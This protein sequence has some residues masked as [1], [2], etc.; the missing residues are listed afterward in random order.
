MK[1]GTKVILGVIGV[2]IIGGAIGANGD[3]KPKE[4]TTPEKS[5]S[6]VVTTTPQSKTD[7][8]LTVKSTT[9]PTTTSESKTEAVAPII[10]EPVTEAP[11]EPSETLS[12]KNALRSAK[13]YISMMGFSYTGLIQQLEFEGYPH[14]DAVYGA[15]NCNA[16][17]FA[18]AAESAKNYI[19]MMPMSRDELINQ[20]EFEGFTSEQAEHGAQAVGY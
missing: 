5:V 16:D 9:A 15:D 17:W 3:N 8:T 4:T 2:L 6:A 12:Q 19:N 11:T 14:E 13:N 10:T 18:E 7:K 20:L 1:K